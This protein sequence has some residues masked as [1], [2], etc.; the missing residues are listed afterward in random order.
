VLWSHTVKCE[1]GVRVFAQ[2]GVDSDELWFRA[3]VVGV[4]RSDVGQWVD[5]EYDDGDVE[6]MK[7]IKVCTCRAL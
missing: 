3:T 7:P 5:V 4:H 1:V 2:Y 6:T